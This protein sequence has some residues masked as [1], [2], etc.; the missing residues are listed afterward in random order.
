MLMIR[1]YRWPIMIRVA[2]RQ[3]RKQL[4]KFAA[5]ISSHCMSVILGSNVSRVIPALLTIMSSRLY[6]VSICSNSFSIDS[7]SVTS[8]AMATASPPA[9]WI[10]ETV[11]A[12]LSALRATQSTLAPFSPSRTATVCPNPCEAPVT[13]AIWPERSADKPNEFKDMF[14][15]L[16]RR[17]I[18][19]T[20]TSCF[21]IHS[22]QRSGQHS[23]CTDFVK[24]IH[25]GR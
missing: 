11:S 15:F 19:K 20:F 14:T 8:H 13:S 25:P 16:S 17:L 24:L 2:P 22:L 5:M 10:C 3:N 12:S 18:A 6:S 4:V 21:A 23:A 1:P 7:R 9:A